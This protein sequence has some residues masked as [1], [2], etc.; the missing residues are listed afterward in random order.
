MGRELTGSS[1]WDSPHH[2]HQSHP[3]HLC[4]ASMCASTGLLPWANKQQTHSLWFECTTL[5][6]SCRFLVF[7]DYM[8]YIYECGESFV[9][10]C[11][12]WFSALSY[13][14]LFWGLRRLNPHFQRGVMGIPF[15]QV[16]IRVWQTQTGRNV[17]WA[18]ITLSGI[19][20][21]WAHVLAW[22]IL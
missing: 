12:V 1:T 15:G 7:E 22:N 20:R 13:W 19:L 17:S 2:G 6:N 3:L 4:C 21:L 18:L 16:K 10:F 11:L 5:A 8:S 14:V 9:L